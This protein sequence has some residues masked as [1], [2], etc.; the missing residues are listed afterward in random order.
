MVVILYVANE[1]TYDTYHPDHERIYRI[2]YRRVTAIGDFTGASTPAP[3]AVAIREQ[4]SQAESVARMIPPFENAKHVLVTRGENALFRE[5]GLVRRSRDFQDLAH[6]F[7]GRATPARPWRSR[8]QSSS[9]RARPGNIS[10]PCR[11]WAA[12]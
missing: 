3:L 4:L 12:A 5:A 1:L 2:A 7:P 9:A 10:A 11:R 8:K 6:P